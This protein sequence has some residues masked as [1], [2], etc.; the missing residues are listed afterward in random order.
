MRGSLLIP[1]ARAALL[2]MVRRRDIAVAGIFLFALLAFLAAA[3]TV[4][5]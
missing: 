4:C 2:D 3:R 1:L 5:Q